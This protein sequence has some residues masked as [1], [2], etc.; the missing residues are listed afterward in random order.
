MR[1]IEQN[2]EEVEIWKPVVNFESRYEVSNLGRIKSL[3]SIRNGAN[4][5]SISSKILKQY[6]SRCGYQRVCLISEDGKR[7]YKSVHRI[8]IS[9]FRGKDSEK[10]QVNHINGIKADNRLENLEWVTQSENMLHAYAIGLEK[11]CDNGFKKSIQ[12][13]KSGKVI[14]C[15]LSIRGMCRELNLD[16]R[17][18]RRTILGE[19]NNYKGLTFKEL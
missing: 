17:S 4:N 13:I 1:D 16:K 11:P 6:T 14:G 18:V 9:T 8:V 3:I 19:K 5:N 7:N 15:Y 2:K 12:V 10:N